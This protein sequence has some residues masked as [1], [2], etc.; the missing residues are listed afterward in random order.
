MVPVRLPIPREGSAAKS[1]PSEA[2]GPHTSV[3]TSAA[4]AE[5]I[6]AGVILPANKEKVEKLTFD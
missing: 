5:K 1:V 3:M 4:T 6:L 2:L